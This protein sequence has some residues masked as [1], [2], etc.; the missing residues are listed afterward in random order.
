MNT[1]ILIIFILALCLVV[2]GLLA[3]IVKVLLGILIV[4][5]FIGVIWRLFA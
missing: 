5:L 1:F 4:L 3:A 2:S